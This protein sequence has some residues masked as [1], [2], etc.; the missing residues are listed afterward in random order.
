V[1][2]SRLLDDYHNLDRAQPPALEGLR[3]VAAEPYPQNEHTWLAV[4]TVPPGALAS[5]LPGALGHLAHAW[6][7]LRRGGEGT[8]IIVDGGNPAGRLVPILNTLLPIRRRKILLWEAHIQAEKPLS[9]WLAVKLVQGCDRIAVYSRRLIALQ[10]AFTGVSQT[11]FFFLP[12]KANHSRSEPITRRLG[13]YVFSGGNSQ[14][15]YRTLLDAVRGTE[16]PVVISSTQPGLTSGLD[17]PENVIVLAAREPAFARLMAGSRFVVL[18]IFPGVV[19]G[20]ANASVCNAMWHGRAVVAADDA[21]L[22]EYI[23]EGVT[24]YSVPAGDVEALR[25][26]I[27]ELFRDRER[28]ESM[29]RAAHD[30][31]AADRT[32][33][34]FLG[35]LNRVAVLMAAGG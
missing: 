16:V 7:I 35:R 22:A 34:R 21:S 4:E 17:V 12:Y 27:L 25:A 29:G 24:G 8:A 33:A 10:A 30:H 2:L 3:L 19:V 13:D 11:R 18:P 26:R 1:D 28:A 32:H 14:R 31:I 20:A 15:D 23:E 5:V 6:R 9:R